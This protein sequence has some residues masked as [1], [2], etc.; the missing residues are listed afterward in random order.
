MSHPESVHMNTKGMRIIVGNE[1]YT[2]VIP[3]GDFLLQ[4]FVQS[5]LFDHDDRFVTGASSSWLTAMV[6]LL[7][8]Q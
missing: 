5:L 1:G 3:P 8:G 6:S 4:C 2:D 7:Y